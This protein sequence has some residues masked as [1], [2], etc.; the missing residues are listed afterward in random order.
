[1]VQENKKRLLVAVDGSEQALEAVRYVS[2][3]LPP[4]QVQVTLLHVMTKVPESFWDLSREPVFHYKIASIRAWEIQQ[5]KT[6]HDFM[7]QARQILLEAGLPKQSIVSHIKERK[8]GIARDIVAESK[9]GYQAVV[10]GRTGLSELKDLVLGSIANKL[11]EKVTHVPVW[12]VGGAPQPGKILI[13]LDASR[14]AMQAVDYVG[15]MVDGFTRNVT[16][17]HVVRGVDIFRQTQSESFASS[18]DTDWQ[19]Q[20]EKELEEATQAI[21]PV[22]EDARE[23]LQQA[24]LDADRISTKLISGVHSR[25]GAIVKEADEEGYGTIVVGRRGLS[26]V[27]EFFIGRVG[28][29]VIQLAKKKAIWVVS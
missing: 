27:E 19:A 21:Q 15:T 6:M 9:H 26:R 4:E 12:I 11:V 10:V 29:K 2:G 22:F 13:A 20:A 5:E 24:G 28:N 3:V 8:A 18:H 14:G 17:I 16:L 23:R 1:M 25:A 7:E